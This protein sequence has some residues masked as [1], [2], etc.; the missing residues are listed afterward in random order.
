[1]AAVGVH[2]SGGLGSA[3]L[4]S[5]TLG[6][7]GGA[8][9]GST[10]KRDV[11]KWLQSL[12]LSHSVSNVKRD[13]QNGFLVA[14]ICSRYY[15][16]AVQMHA[17]DNGV[18]RAAKADNWEQLTKFC[19]PR[20]IPVDTAT[21]YA[22]SDC[23]Q[24]A[25]VSLLERLYEFFTNRKLQ[26]LPREVLEAQEATLAEAARRDAANGTRGRKPRGLAGLKA[27]ARAA[28][29]SA[30][31]AQQAAVLEQA[32][33]EQAE[34]AADGDAA[35][36]VAAAAAASAG[37][38]GGGGSDAPVGGPPG[39]EP[40]IFAS[41]PLAAEAK[42]PPSVQFGEVKVTQLESALEV[43]KRLA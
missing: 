26:Q 30:N 40:P 28:R 35:A 27:T 19:L 41:R 10:L 2:T 12:D 17:F 18:G 3:T 1:M 22:V 4:G 24:G 6:G 32:A 15:G 11:L 43:R 36:P 20:D 31:A 14:E 5:A 21:A 34:G 33:E 8:A 38:G 42:P 39:V 25:A 13:L 37:G 16:S 7:V 29:S 23:Q 9:A